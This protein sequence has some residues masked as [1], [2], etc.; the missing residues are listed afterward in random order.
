MKLRRKGSCSEMDCVIDYVERSLKGEEPACPKSNYSVHNTIIGHFDQLLSNEKRMSNAAKQVLDI[1]TS[2][3][4]FDVEMSFISEELLYFAKELADLS[5]SNLSIVEET[6]AAMNEVNATIDNTAETLEHLSAESAALAEKND[7]SK[8]LLNEVSGLKENVT[9]DTQDMNE[10]ITQLVGLAD[11]VGKIV[12]SVQGIANQTNL[13]ALNAAIEAARAGEHGKGFAVVA[14]EVRTLA[15]DT[16]QNLSGMEKFVSEIHAAAEG[17]KISMERTLS[18][19]AVMGEKIDAVSHTVG[20]NIDMLNG[21]ILSVG[22]IHHS[23]QGIKHAADD[24]NAAMETS[25]QNAEMLA[26]MTQNIH[27]DADESVAFS[28]NISTID[29]N[30]SAVSALLY[31]GLREGRHAVS[32]EELSSVII[33]ARD[34]HIVWMKK[35]ERMADTMQLSP[36]QTNSQ[37]CAFGHFYYALKIDHPAIAKEWAQIAPIHKELH[38]LGEQVIAAVKAGKQPDALNYQKK[39]DAA[40]KQ[41]IDLLM[42]VNAKVNDLSKKQMRV[43]E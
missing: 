17:G 25:S 42:A 43:F 22:D 14:D 10:K 13:L 3:S 34:A 36:L 32:N 24:I 9:K 18:S 11:E 8:S 28:K 21:V 19:T 6:T 5:E 27:Y 23:M 4:S 37:K 29:N 38:T 1:A 15:D 31:D 7:E 2:I 12:V 39:A 26:K 30:L 41:I 35:L 16:K 40:S 33:K 20:D